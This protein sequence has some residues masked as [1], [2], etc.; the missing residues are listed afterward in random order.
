MCMLS[1]MMIEAMLPPTPH[2][3]NVSNILYQLVSD[4]NIEPTI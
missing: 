4:S 1:F 2:T 3:V